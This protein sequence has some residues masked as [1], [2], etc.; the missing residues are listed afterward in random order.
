[1]GIIGLE[2]ETCLLIELH[3]IELAIWVPNW[4]VNMPII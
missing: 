3:K 4:R 2:G 1:M